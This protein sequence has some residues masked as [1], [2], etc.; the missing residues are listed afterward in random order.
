MAVEK[1]F[2][3]TMFRLIDEVCSLG[4]EWDYLLFFYILKGIPAAS[5]Q[6]RPFLKCQLAACL[7][8]SNLEERTQL[9]P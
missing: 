3:A 8:P 5:A 6:Y 4:E 2:A 1:K 7:S 9:K